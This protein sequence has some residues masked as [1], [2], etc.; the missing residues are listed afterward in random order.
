MESQ[1]QRGGVMGQNLVETLRI[2]EP[3]DVFTRLSETFAIARWSIQPA[4]VGFVAEA[5]FCA[6]SA[7]A[8]AMGASSPCRHYCLDALTEVVQG[9]SPKSRLKVH[10]TLWEG[11][12]CRVEVR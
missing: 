5:D 11:E 6:L 7:Q 10:E 12:R 1:L 8:K 3:Q 4:E 2:R 9:L